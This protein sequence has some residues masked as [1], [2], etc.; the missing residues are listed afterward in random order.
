MA[1]ST[2]RPPNILELPL[3]ERAEMALKA[4]V[5][6][7]IESHIRDGRPI[8]IWREGKVVEVSAQELRDTPV[9]PQ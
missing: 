4:A 3:G 5:E 9:K 8:S 7:V 6:K 1:D 2:K